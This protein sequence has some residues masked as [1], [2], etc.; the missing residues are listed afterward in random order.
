MPK[1]ADI[2]A[3]VEKAHHRLSAD[4]AWA[5][6][7]E[8][9]DESATVCVTEEML[10]A[11]GAAQAVW[12]YGDKVGARMA[13]KGAY[14]RITSERRNQ[15]IAPQWQL[16]LGWDQERRTAAA[17]EALRLGRMPLE[18]VQTF[19]PAPAPTGIGAQIAGLLA[20]KTN[21]L[22]FP[23]D[24]DAKNRRRMQ[25]LREHL[26]AQPGPQKRA[27]QPI[28]RDL[29]GESELDAKIRAELA[30]QSISI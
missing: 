22:A 6:A 5:I 1:P 4:E 9:F 20:G 25:E 10:E 19:L 8:S 14:E 12:E 30:A 21:V 16:S 24:Q 26:A 18:D 23:S 3:I 29:I 11:L 2:I 17:Q 15:G 27:A 7:L 13:F 28:K